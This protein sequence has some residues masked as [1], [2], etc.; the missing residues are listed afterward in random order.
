MIKLI[1]RIGVAFLC[2][3]VSSK[4]AFSISY[5]VDPSSTAT[6]SNGTLTSPWKTIAEVNAGTTALNP[7]DQVLFKRGQTYSG[8]LIVWKSGTSLYPIVYGNYGSGDL[9]EFTNSVSDVISIYQK[10]YIIIDGIR[11]T[12]RSISITDHAVQAKISY[13]I[14]VNNSPNCTIKNCTISLVGVGISVTQGSDNTT[15][16]G[17]HFY[18]L[19]MVRN[20]PTNINSNDDYGANPMVIGSSNNTISYNRFEECW[21][22]SYDYGYDGGAVELFGSAVNNNKIIYNTAIN[23]DGFTEIGSASGGV[24]NNNVVAYNKII[25][26]GVVGTFQNS[27]T[28]Y[29]N[30]NNLQFYNNTIVETI[31][32]YQRAANLFWM[33]GTGAAGM[34]VVRNNIFWLST[35]VNVAQNKFGSGQL[36][37]SNNIYRMTSGSLGFVPA[38]NELVGN[39]ISL[40]SNTSA[41]PS[42][43]NYSPIMNSPAVNFGTAVGFNTDFN[44]NPINGN[45][46]A[47]IIEQTSST[48]IPALNASVSVQKILCYGGTTSLTVSATGGIAPYIGTG[49]FQVTAGT[50][51]YTVKDAIGNSSIA[52]VTVTQPNALNQTL[53][54]GSLTTLG[55]TTFISA[56]VSGGTKPYMY[57]INNGIAQTE[58]I[59]TNLSAGNYTVKVIDQ[60]LCNTA[61]N[62][63][64]KAFSIKQNDTTNNKHSII[65]YPNPSNNYFSLFIGAF[66]DAKQVGIEVYNLMG[67]Q[68]FKTNAAVGETIRFGQQF[69]SG[70]YFAKV[71]FPQKTQTIKLIKL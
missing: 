52:S 61:N 31:L 39:S 48:T 9:P 50:Y 18:N 64:I 21:A 42:S 67:A 54:A 33:S 6:T 8:K 68:V 70:A 28:F 46:D 13:A 34:V 32:H 25:N 56:I 59:F 62:I 11:I 45:P 40:F 16:T 36:I 22:S 44:R 41:D 38:T 17:N 24:C 65:V 5:Y 49:T 37:H 60:N 53:E 35:G 58:N 7:G 23:C 4:Q 69:V 12:D 3:I 1:T 15:I 66:S 10:Q 55:G 14:V 27:G 20:T 71:V 2:T 57:S 63:S 51:S 19:R 47:G 26:C 30:I 43:W 29:I